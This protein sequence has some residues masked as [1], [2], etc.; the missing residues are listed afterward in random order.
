MRLQGRLRTWSSTSHL[1]VQHCC[2]RLFCISYTSVSHTL[3]MLVSPT[4]PGSAG[5]A[6]GECRGCPALPS[7]PPHGQAS[8]APAL[9]AGG[10]QHLGSREPCAQPSAQQIHCAYTVVRPSLFSRCRAPP[11]AAGSGPSLLEEGQ[12]SSPFARHQ[13]PPL[14]FEPAGP[15]SGEAPP[16]NRKGPTPWSS[17]GYL[18]GG[19]LPV[20]AAPQASGSRPPSRRTS[21]ETG[22]PPRPPLAQLGG[23]VRVQAPAPSHLQT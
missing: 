11:A 3:T 23:T 16:S 15:S 2:N 21:M 18:D 5:R 17:L 10:A 20:P 22:R 6:G 19:G 4:Y 7:A 8:G 12:P 14:A 13:G 9:C 1:H